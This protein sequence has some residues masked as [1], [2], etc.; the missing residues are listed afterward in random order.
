MMGDKYSNNAFSSIIDEEQIKIIQYRI[1]KNGKIID[2]IVNN[3]VS[4]YC[5]QMDT[6]I[7]K[8]KNLMEDSRNPPSDVELEGWVIE[9]PILLYFSGE[10]QE[11]LGVK[12]DIAK[13]IRMEL[14]NE[15]RLDAKGTVAD[16]NSL[17]ESETQTEFLV[18]V[19]YQRAYKKIKLRMELGNE[20]LQSIKKVIS[21]R[22][23]EYELGKNDPHKVRN[24]TRV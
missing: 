9:L 14:Y 13:A 4:K 19:V 2:D 23:A 7:K 18:Q 15:I 3:L 11:A 24:R 5:G 16:K 1:D 10:G 12:E 17:A 21:R 8:V 20:L 22:I 6:F